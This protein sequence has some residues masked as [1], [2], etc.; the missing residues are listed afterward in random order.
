MDKNIKRVLVFLA[1]TF[2]ITYIYEFGVI[3]PIAHK[4]GYGTSTVQGLVALCMFIPALSVLLT[5]LITRE[6]F[7]DCKIRPHIKGNVKYYLLAWFSMPVFCALA[8]VLYFVIFPGKFAPRMEL[9]ST[10]IMQCAIAV[11]LG[12]VLNCIATFG[13]EWGW[14]GYLMPKLMNKMSFASASIIS[15]FIW[16]IW[17]APIIAL[18]H[19]YGTAYVGAPW[20]GI[21]MMC[22]F[23][24]TSGIIFSWWCV[25]TDSCIPAVIGHASVNAIAAAPL[26]LV[27]ANDNAL[28]GPTIAGVVGIIVMG[29]YAG[30]ILY[31]SR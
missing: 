7:T 11:F 4:S 18:G 8:A 15:G 29:I 23:C 31:R 14:R 22:L 17:H 13:E 19:N 12:P 24:I 21:L 10:M 16:G 28:V 3:T 5:R 2:A 6:G 30:F 20:L 1:I 9:M 25:K 27:T 26:F